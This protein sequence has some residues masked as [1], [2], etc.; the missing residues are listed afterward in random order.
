MSY[1]QAIDTYNDDW[2]SED[3]QALLNYAAVPRD[4]Q[5]HTCGWVVCG[6][7]CNSVLFPNEFSAHLRAHGVRGGGN[8]KMSCCWVGCTEQMNTECVVRHVLEVHLELRYECP[9]CGRTFSRKTSLNNHRKQE[10]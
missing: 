2:S 8:A 7:P 3:E 4:Q 1:Y 5:P 6:E 10:H 9:D